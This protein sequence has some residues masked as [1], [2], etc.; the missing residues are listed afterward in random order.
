MEKPTRWQ[1]LIKSLKYNFIPFNWIRHVR[2]I[3]KNGHEYHVYSHDEFKGIVQKISEND[4]V[5]S[6]SYD[7]LDFKNRKI[8][9]EVREFTIPLF[10][11]YFPTKRK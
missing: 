2:V 11:K 7:M 4:S 10:E 8:K 3:T 9:K 1:S 6:V 5:A